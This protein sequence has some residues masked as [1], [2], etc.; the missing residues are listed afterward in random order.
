[1]LATDKEIIPFIKTNGVSEDEYI[2][3]AYVKTKAGG[4]GLNVTIGDTTG[5]LMSVP[6]LS[7]E[8][9]QPEGK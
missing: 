7:H 9:Y 6:F 3:L 8:Y 5:K 2:G 4:E 1:M